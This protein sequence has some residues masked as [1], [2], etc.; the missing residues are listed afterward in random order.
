MLEFSSNTF[1]DLADLLDGQKLA[2]FFLSEPTEPAAQDDDEALL[3]VLLVNYIHAP[4]CVRVEGVMA[5]Q[6]TASCICLVHM[7]LNL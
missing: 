4:M 7:L 6:H 2:L 1:Q 5:A 3:A